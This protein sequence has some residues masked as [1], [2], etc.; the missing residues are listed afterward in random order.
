MSEAADIVRQEAVAKRAHAPLRD[1]VLTGSYFGPR[2]AA[3]AEPVAAFPHLTPWQAL[4]AWF[5]PADAH[6]LAA[7]PAACRGAL[8][9]DI[10]ALDLLIGEQLD[11]ILH[12]PRVRR[13]EGS[14]RG[15][16]WL[17]GG[18]DPASR[19]K[20]KVLNIGWAELC[21][22]LERAVEFDQSNLF[23][24]VY[25]EEFGTPGGEP[26]GLLVIDHEVRHRP[27][28]GAPTDDVTGLVQLAGM[29]AAAFAPTVLAASP[30]L[31]QVEEFADLAM[32]TDV[33]DPFRGPE[34]TR[35]RGLSTREDMR[36]LGVTLPRV[37]ARAPWEDDPARTDG[38]RYAE[39]AP[40][41]DSRVWM[42]AGYAF[43]AV[44]ARA[45]LNHAWPADVRGSEV[46]YVGGG[47]VTDLPI[48]P[49]RTD[50]DHVWVRPP[51]DLILSDRMEAALVEAGL[52][53]LSALPYGEEAVFSA[54]RSLQ[55]PA[56]Y[57][58]PTAAAANANARLSAQL[59]SILCASRFAHYVKVMGRNMVGAF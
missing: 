21:R 19:V 4:A 15:L 27:A 33:S 23:R 28:P 13:V 10:A 41:A 8:D 48:E 6:R 47:L 36:F 30:A 14:W 25:E 51:L 37:L 43:A 59:N 12:H 50:P 38:F 46:D 57:A 56:S 45:F 18:L 54:V 26:Y 44:V 34:F 16:A 55:A 42:N 22:D 49:F 3:A 40:N 35:W 31:L 53:P 39:Y 2:Y 24:K 1:R 5:G 11:A 9:R 32:S 17:T 29:A 52:M 20:V 58:G 7:D